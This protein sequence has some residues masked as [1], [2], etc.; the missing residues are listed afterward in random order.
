MQ[1]CEIK[2]AVKGTG[3]IRRALAFQ[4]LLM[5]DMDGAKK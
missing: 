5:A 4:K 3:P 1:H 2:H